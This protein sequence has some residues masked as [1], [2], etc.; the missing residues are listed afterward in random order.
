MVVVVL[1]VGAWVGAGKG[2]D[3]KGGGRWFRD[4]AK[5]WP[6]LSRSC[7][8][9]ASHKEEQLGPPRRCPARHE[10]GQQ[11]RLKE[12]RAWK[13]TKLF[14]TSDCTMSLR[15]VSRFRRW[16]ANWLVLCRFTICVCWGEGGA[17]K[18]RCRL[19]YL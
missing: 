4:V 19:H 8:E 7:R 16:L 9:L 1:W 5:C 6:C 12:R 2:G 18:G 13:S 14:S 3:G 15:Q 17:E 11:A 10:G